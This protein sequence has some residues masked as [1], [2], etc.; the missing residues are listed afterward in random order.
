MTYLRSRLSRIVLYHHTWVVGD[1][2]VRSE[3]VQGFKGGIIKVLC[4]AVS[5]GVKSD[6]M[7]VVIA[8]VRLPLLILTLLLQIIPT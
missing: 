1:I 5:S 7:Y 4:I 6:N 2:N 3:V 8:L